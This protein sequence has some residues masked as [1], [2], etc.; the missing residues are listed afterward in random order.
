MSPTLGMSTAKGGFVKLVAVFLFVTSTLLI[1]SHG[2]HTACK[3]SCN[4]D[5]ERL[6]L[7]T[8]FVCGQQSKQIS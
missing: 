1:T 5:L 4:G 2:R 3:K 7:E 6:A 8:Q